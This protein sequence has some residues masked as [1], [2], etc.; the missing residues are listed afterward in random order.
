MHGATDAPTVDV[1]ESGVLGVTAVDDASYGDFAGYLAL[2][3]DDYT[4]QVRTSDNAAIVATYGAPL[5]T[6]G[7]DEALYR[8]RQR[9]PEPC[10][11]QRWP[12]LRSLGRVG[13]RWCT[14]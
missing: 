14:R 5:A 6:L 8:A 1:Y 2:P 10:E 12:C 13:Q 3:T 9:F 4:L 11:Q 7:L